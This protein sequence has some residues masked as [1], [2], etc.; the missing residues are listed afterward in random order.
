MPSQPIIDHYDNQNVHS[1]TLT[2]MLHVTE[3][4]GHPG[5]ELMVVLRTSKAELAEKAPAHN[6]LADS[7][8]DAR[9][10]HDEFR[11]HQLMHG[12]AGHTPDAAMTRHLDKWKLL[13]MVYKAYHL[14]PDARFYLFIEANTAHVE[15]YSSSYF[16]LLV[17]PES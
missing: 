6:A 2:P 14:R 11:E 5:E 13:P 8:S 1:E 7:G 15:F 9:R 10:T 16:P 4:G 3:H 17:K 12:D